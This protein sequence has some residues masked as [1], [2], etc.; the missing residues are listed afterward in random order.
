MLKKSLS[1]F[2]LWGLA[3][4]MVI[5]GEYF[6]WNFGWDQAGTLGFLISSLIVTVLYCC[7]VLSYAE[8]TTAIP[9]AGGPVA[10]AYKAFGPMAG[11]I[12]G[13]A[14]LIEFLFAPPAIAF[15]LGSYGHFLSADVSVLATA[16]AAYAVFSLINLFGIKESA[17]FNLLVTG[18][19][20]LELLVFI[21]VVGADF[22]WDRFLVNGLPHG[23]SGIIAGLPYAVWL[24]LGIEGLAM[25][26]EEVH[27][28]N[29]TIPKA[30]L[31]GIA[32]LVVL[33][34]GVMLAAGG[35]GDWQALSRIDYPLPE[36]ISQVMGK[37]SVLSYLFASLGLFGLLASFHGLMVAYSRQLFALSRSGLLPKLLSQVNRRFATPHWALLLGGLIGILALLTGATDQL[38]IMSALG[39][40]VMYCM[41]MLSLLKLKQQPD[42]QAGFRA[43]AYPW[44]PLVALVLSGLCVLTLIYFNPLISVWFLLGLVLTAV[45]YRYTVDHDTVFD[46]LDSSGD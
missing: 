43:P 33:A 22:S 36:A 3:V 17:V 4:G 2:Q 41:A 38:I 20:V 16:I 26:A 9:H 15:A 13:Y 27:E 40:L 44:L 45:L 12:A 28:P 7:F 39:A 23:L 42:F 11:L 29:R 34:L 25:L 30:Y 8:L 31:T 19:A 6:G 37:A 14:T 18:L 21:G 46:D 32:T 1:A 24:F 10:Y 5:S 35:V